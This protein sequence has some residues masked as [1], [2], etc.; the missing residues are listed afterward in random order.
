MLKEFNYKGLLALEGESL[1]NFLQRARAYENPTLLIKE[2]PLPPHEREEIDLFDLE[3]LKVRFDLYP[4]WVYLFFSNHRLMFWEAACTWT[5]KMENVPYPVLQFRKELKA[6]KRYFGYCFQEVFHHEVIHAVR[7]GLNSSR[8]EEMIC[9]RSSNNWLRR[10]LSAIF[11]TPHET[12][13]YVM[14]WLLTLLASFAYMI[15]AIDF[16]FFLTLVSALCGTALTIWGIARL[17]RNARLLKKALSRLA[18]I[19]APKFAEAVLV[20]LDDKEIVAFAKKDK[21]ALEKMIEEKGASSLRWQQILA[22]Y[23]P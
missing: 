11:Q 2:L 14:V 17:F 10:F 18:E 13:L 4:T 3:E 21:K 23:S 22:C 15:F 6:K 20:R 16:L 5:F 12:V 1:Q 9:Y 7:S 8:F 19:F